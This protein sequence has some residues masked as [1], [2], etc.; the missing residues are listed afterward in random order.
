MSHRGL[1]PLPGYE[2]KPH[3]PSWG[4]PPPNIPAHMAQPYYQNPSYMPYHYGGP[5]TMYGQPNARQFTKP[6]PGPTYNHPVVQDTEI[7]IAVDEDIEKTNKEKKARRKR[8]S[9]QG[10]TVPDLVRNIIK[11]DADLKQARGAF[12]KIVDILEEERELNVFNEF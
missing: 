2:N 1:V 11:E 7:S 12:R 8:L 6:M 4:R 5:P 10:D 3:L 9:I